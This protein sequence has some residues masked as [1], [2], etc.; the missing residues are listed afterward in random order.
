MKWSEV[1]K[2]AK[3]YILYHSISSPTLVVWY[4]LPL[5]ML[6]TG[7]NI[8]SI[9]ALYTGVSLANAGLTYLVGK[10][11][12]RLP[13]KQGL[14]AIEGFGGVL[15]NLFYF[16]SK[17]PIASV[18]VFAGKLSEDMSTLFFPLFQAYEKAIYP[19]EK[20]EEILAWHM[21][22]PEITQ[23]VFFPLFGYFLGRIY[24]TPNNWR[25]SFLAFGLVSIFLLIWMWKFLPSIGKEEHLRSKF[26]V[27]IFGRE[28]GWIVAV[29]LIS[30]FAISIAPTIILINYVFNALGGGLFEIMIVEVGISIS[31][32][33][34]SYVSEKINKKYGFRVMSLGTIL[35]MA[36]AIVMFMRPVFPIVIGAYIIEEFGNTLRFPFYRS[37]I[38]KNIPS[39]RST[40]IF[41]G[42]ASAK[43][44]MGI[45]TPLVA[46]ALASR[47]DVLPFGI[48]FLLWLFLAISYVYI[49]KFSRYAND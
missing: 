9:G 33:T 7:Y 22:L 40:E 10:I 14:L 32:I 34:A 15:S 48:S 28:F 18:M 44:I 17:G 42:I 27:N 30:Y 1:P 5:Y 4:I 25:L 37:W 8:L 41:G 29:E 26:E 39:K 11:F 13:I 12:N 46:G 35:T 21:R 2:D 3:K 38:Y 49:E 36:W 23:L 16:L 24:N 19:E 45:V 47:S 20:R 31:S 43:R 6:S